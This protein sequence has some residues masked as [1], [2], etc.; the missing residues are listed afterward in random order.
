MLSEQLLELL[1]CPVCRGTLVY[2]PDRSLLR[3]ERCRK[4]YRVEE[5]IPVMREEGDGV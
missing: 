2:V 4:D 5:D 1:R 3:C